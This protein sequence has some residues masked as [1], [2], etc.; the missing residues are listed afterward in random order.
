MSGVCCECCE[1]T[2]E[3]E[4]LCDGVACSCAMD[5]PQLVPVNTNTVLA[6]K[7]VGEIDA[8]LEELYRTTV[9][10]KR[11]FFTI[12]GIHP[13]VSQ[14]LQTVLQEWKETLNGIN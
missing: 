12:S 14:R 8:M 7:V 9:R 3:Q 13:E 4:K 6:Q 10:Q 5:S 1:C 11:T 2:D